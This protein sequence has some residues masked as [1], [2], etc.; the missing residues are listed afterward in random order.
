M[1]LIAY[2]CD[3]ANLSAANLL[4][5]KPKTVSREGYECKLGVEED[6]WVKKGQV[7]A[8]IG[9]TGSATGPH[10]HY[11]VRLQNPDPLNPFEVI[12][13]PLPFITEGL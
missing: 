6:D 11:E 8:L 2:F 4:L 3:K 10:V 7:I 5:N 1:L 12:L 9:Q 13:N